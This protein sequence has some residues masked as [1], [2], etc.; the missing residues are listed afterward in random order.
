MA[1]LY[2]LHFTVK[3][4]DH[5]GH[6]LGFTRSLR[7]RLECHRAGQGSPLIRALLER[8]G[9]FQVARTWRPGSR[10]LERQLKRQRNLPRFCPTCRSGNVQ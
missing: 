9:D 2:L 8:G 3:V 10:T 1:S 5:A 6:Y 4:A 7:D